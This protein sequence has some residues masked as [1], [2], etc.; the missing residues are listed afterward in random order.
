[1][2]RIFQPLSDAVEQIVRKA[3]GCGIEVHR[4]LGPG[5]RESI[6][7]HAFCLELE[8][9]GMKFVR[10]KSISVKYKSWEIPGQR[11]DLIVEDVVLVEIKSVSRLKSIH[12]RQV[13]SYLRST[14]LRVGL[15]MNFNSMMLKDGLQ[16]V[17]R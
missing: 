1:M 8:L 11:V 16:R 9:Q 10:E 6:Y 14:E 5:F 12:R 15:L 13:V 4:V 3:I 7:T 17:V 2:F